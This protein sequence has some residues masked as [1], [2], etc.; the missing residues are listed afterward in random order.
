MS[1][2]TKE[3]ETEKNCHFG[4]LLLI[5]DAQNALYLQKRVEIY[6]AI[7]GD[8]FRGFRRLYSNHLVT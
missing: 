4:Q 1:F 3:V 6:S 7:L 5:K 8:F 2:A